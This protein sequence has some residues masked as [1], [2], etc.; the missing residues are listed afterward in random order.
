MFDDLVGNE[1]LKKYLESLIA[2]QKI[3]HALLFAGPAGVGKGMFAKQFAQKLVQS[4]NE[5]HPDIH[6]YFP[7][8]KSGIHSMETMRAFTEE[9]TLVPYMAPWKVFILYDAERMQA[10]SANALLK[11]FEEPSPRTVI[12]L[13]TDSPESLLTTILSRCRLLQ[14]KAVNTN[15]M[16]AWL[17]AKYALDAQEAL[18]L[19]RQSKGSVA[20]AMQLM[21]KKEDL[22]ESH[23]LP[24][25]VRG[26]FNTFTELGKTAQAIATQIDALKT[27][28]EIEGDRE[29]TAVQ[30]AQLEKSL[31]GAGTMLYLRQVQRFLESLSGWY[32]DVILMKC[33]GDPQSLWHARHSEEIKGVAGHKLPL[34]FDQVL[35]AINEALISVQRS[36]PLQSVLETLFLRLKL[37]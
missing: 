37:L 1:P 4:Q 9:V 25:L 11:T 7:E 22:F 10:Y 28:T 6:E 31:A 20:Y 5:Q 3:P 19:A 21:E 12:I 16:T 15:E 33:G 34:N 29:M 35:A 13:V 23:L 26:R 8:G 36:S 14:F 2:H 32:R 30:K 18:I 17:E 27:D 24:I